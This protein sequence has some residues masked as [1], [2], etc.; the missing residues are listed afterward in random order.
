MSF[1]LQKSIKTSYKRKEMDVAPTIVLTDESDEGASNPAPPTRKVERWKCDICCVETFPTIEECIAHEEICKVNHKSQKEE[2]KQQLHPFFELSK[3]KQPPPPEAPKPSKKAKA[4]KNTKD[5]RIIVIDD[6]S[7]SDT[8]KKVAPVSNTNDDKDLQE[9]AAA[10]GVTPESL[11]A[12]QKALERQ[13]DLRKQQKTSQPLEVRNSLSHWKAFDSANTSVKRRKA[14]LDTQPIKDTS[15]NELNALAAVLGVKPASLLAEQQAV[16]LKTHHRQ[17]AAEKHKSSQDDPPSSKSPA[18]IHDTMKRRKGAAALFPSPN[19]VTSSENNDILLKEAPVKDW[20]TSDLLQNMKNRWISSFSQSNGNEKDFNYPPIPLQMGDNIQ[21]EPKT[22]I[23]DQKLFELLSRNLQVLPRGIQSPELWVDRFRMRHLP[24][25][26]CGNKSQL[27]ELQSFLKEWKDVRQKC[28]KHMASK[29]VKKKTPKAKKYKDDDDFMDSDAEE[30]F[31]LPSLCL[32]SGPV[33]CGKSDLVRALVESNDCRLV[34]ISTVEKRGAAALKRAIGEATQSLSSSDLM[35]KSKQNCIFGIN[36]VDD[37]VEEEDNGSSLTAILLDEVDILFENNG[38]GGFWQALLDLSRKAK[39]PIFLTA[40]AIDS[41]SFYCEHVQ[42]KRPLPEECT[43]RL[44][45]IIR[46]SGSF[47]F[48]SDVEADQDEFLKELVRLCGRDM[49]KVTHVLQAYSNSTVSHSLEFSN[50]GITSTVPKSF[51]SN[52]RGSIEQP[53]VNYVHPCRVDS[54]QYNLLEITGIGFLSL[55]GTPSELDIKRGV[56]VTVYVGDRKCPVARILNDSTI[57]AVCQPYPP[58]GRGRKG[59]ISYEPI[60]ICSTRRTGI[61]STILGY[62][63]PLIFPDGSTVLT[64]QAPINIQ[65]HFNAKSST[66]SVP[67]ANQSERCGE[68]SDEEFE[69][70][71]EDQNSKS[72][73]VVCEHIPLDS[74][75]VSQI[76]NDGIDAW[77]TRHPE[78]PEFN[79]HTTKKMGASSDINELRQLCV[80]TELASDAVFLEDVGMNGTPYLAGPTLGFGYNLTEAYPLCSNETS[81]WYVK[82]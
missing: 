82:S 73:D 80:D 60:Q 12:E 49:R 27:L 17:Q 21:W 35:R 1:L 32:V 44:R 57:M 45:R 25:D 65:L 3:R 70:E 62:G 46:E 63:F 28:L 34:E 13:A 33:G 29:H 16:E 79:S 42:M 69:F 15:N 74:E 67:L 14:A 59:S 61:T 7:T 39:S 43:L 18:I 8:A 37:T 4:N 78:G 50:D 5:Q 48:V 71:D 10:L 77:L 23:V 19:H 26:L 38:D 47:Q 53:S 22:E 66:R 64:E 30:D 31:G 9:L 76:I 52:K 36:T 72:A 11:L 68:Q 40:N 51:S 81:K 54:E 58:D 56:P 55:I 24:D 20:L 2:P 6:M 41:P 75:R